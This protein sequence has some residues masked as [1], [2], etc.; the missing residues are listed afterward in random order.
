MQTGYLIQQ[1]KLFVYFSNSCLLDFQC[2]DGIVI[3]ESI[4][5]A[6]GCMFK[7]LLALTRHDIHSFSAVQIA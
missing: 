3:S 7:P 5:N 2:L 1:F 6:I 4:L